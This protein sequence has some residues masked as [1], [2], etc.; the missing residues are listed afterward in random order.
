[1]D[2]LV[3]RSSPFY[4]V[5]PN[6]PNNATELAETKNFLQSLADGDV[7]DNKNSDRIVS[8]RVSLKDSVS[9]D[10]LN[11]HKGIRLVGLENS[12]L[13]QRS[14]DSRQEEKPSAW[15]AFAKDPVNKDELKKSRE[16]LDSKVKDPKQ[17][18]TMNKY[19][20]EMENLGEKLGIIAWGNLTLDDAGVAEAKKYPGFSAVEEDWDIVSTRSADIRLPEEKSRDKDPRTYN[21][22]ES[23]YNLIGAHC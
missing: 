16:W 8:W 3:E 11:N 14:I 17:I 18:G 22:Y 19:S 4:S 21:W 13:G 12:P 6:D 5:F 10:L 2:H 7:L 1:M 15:I 20:F 23:N 9:Q